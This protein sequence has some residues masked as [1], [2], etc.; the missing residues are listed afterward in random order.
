MFSSVVMAGCCPGLD[1]ILLGRES[2]G[3]ITHG[4]KDIEAF[5]S[6]KSGDDV[7]GYIAKRMSYMKPCPGLGRGTCPKNKI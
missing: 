5:Q 1:G 3:I 4:V 6:F 2:K 7:R